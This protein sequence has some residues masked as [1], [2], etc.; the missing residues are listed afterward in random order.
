MKKLFLIVAAMFAAVSFSA[1]SDDDDNKIDPN[2]IAE[3]WQITREVGY[4]IVPGEGKMEKDIT[5][6]IDDVNDDYGFYFTYTFNENGT[7]R[8]KSYYYYDNNRL[9]S[10]WSIEYTISNNQLLMY[11]EPEEGNPTSVYNI[12]ELTKSKLVL[13]YKVDDSD[14][15]KAE[16]TT[17]FKK[18]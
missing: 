12:K 3:T 15:Y 11:E 7:G 10:N 13:L 9:D 2:Q 1:C 18:I 6:P 14:G 8:Y 4:E 5:C 16:I 17:T